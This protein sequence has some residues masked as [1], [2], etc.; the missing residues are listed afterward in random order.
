MASIRE[1]KKNVNNVLGDLMDAVYIVEAA[2]GKYDS[3][4][5][6]KIID[7]AIATFDDL[8]EKI[9]D[10]TVENRKKHL[11]AVRAELESKAQGLVEEIN[12]LG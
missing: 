5:G 8:I 1:L 9:N 6:S 3:K 10:R 2:N 7:S 11:T 4:E 12:K